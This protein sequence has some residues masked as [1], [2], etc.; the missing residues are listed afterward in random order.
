MV[1]SCESK[2]TTTYSNDLRWHVVWQSEVCGY[3]LC[4][5]AEYLNVDVSTVWRVVKQ[6][7]DFGSVDKRHYS[8][9]KSVQKL[10]PSLELHVLHVVLMNPGIYLREIQEDICETTRVE[11]S[12]SAI[13]RFLQ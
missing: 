9:D 13:C 3:K 1:T 12:E 11:I 7:K 8:R 10:T 6:F 4:T 5:V 2:Q